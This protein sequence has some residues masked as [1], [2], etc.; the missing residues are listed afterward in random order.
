[1]L[2]RYVGHDEKPVNLFGAAMIAPMIISAVLMV[3]GYVAPT[4]WQWLA[5]FGFAVL[6]AGAN[7]LLMIASRRSPASR[8]APTQYSQMLWGLLLGYLFF[9]DR[10]DAFTGL[11][12]VVI[13][14]AG[15]WLF[16]PKAA[17][18]EAA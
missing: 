2:L 11:G 4:G 15:L 6:A 10:L 3:P 13:V 1:M 5:I 16:L 14:G 8:I 17:R 9:G 18:R 12:V 7:I